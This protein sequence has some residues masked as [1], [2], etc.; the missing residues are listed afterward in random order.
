MASVQ[1]LMAVYNGEKY[2]SQQIESILSQS[3][4]DWELLI[5]D[6]S[7]TDRS[8]D[9]VRSYCERDARIKLVLD[10]CHFGSAKSHFMALLRIAC[11]PYVMTSDQDDVWDVHKIDLTLKEMKAAEIENSGPLLVCTDLR[12]VDHNL[13]L[14]SPSFLRYSALDAS[15]VDLGYFLASCLVTGC[16]MMVNHQLLLLLQRNVNAD[17]LIMHDWW[18]SLVAAALGKVIYISEP[19]ISYRQHLD[20]S[21]GAVKFS[22]FNGIKKLNERRKTELDAIV[23][24]KELLR[25]YSDLIDGDSRIRAQIDSFVAIE[26][27]GVLKRI[28]L[29]NR[30]GIWRKGILRNAVTFFSLLT[31]N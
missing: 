15:K 5:S 4:Q 13:N 7:S 31:V 25:V 26:S 20:N 9:V 16:T 24:A 30:A 27:A 17:S 19:T 11:A 8:L 29:M 12:V 23:Q 14:I 6:D 21:V 18:A 2:L 22:L 28:V 10:G 3:F 1:I